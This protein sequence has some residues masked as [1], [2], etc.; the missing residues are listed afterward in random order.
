MPVTDYQASVSLFRAGDLDLVWSGG[1]TGVQ[2]RLQTDG[3]D[4]IAQRDIDEAF[5]SV[6][7]ASSAAGGEPFEAG[8]EAGTVEES[9]VGVVFRTPAYHD[10]HWVLGPG[11]VERLGHDLP[12][13]VRDALLGLSADDPD[14]ARI[15]DLFGAQAF[16]PARTSD[17][18]EIEQVGRDL[19][20]V[21]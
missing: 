9:G 16:I 8:V 20:L 10:Y 19:G 11:A 15:L 13:R 7:I 21:Q 3:A 1:L 18:D 17:Y 5:H 12:E 6:F 4:V 2:A 14:E